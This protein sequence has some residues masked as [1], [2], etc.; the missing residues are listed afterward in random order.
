MTEKNPKAAE[1][2]DFF[3]SKLT[4]KFKGSNI[5]ITWVFVMSGGGKNKIVVY[6]KQCNAGSGVGERPEAYLEPNL[7]IYS[8]AFC[9][10]S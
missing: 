8:G 6:K 1:K 9:E 7:N 2:R 5:A 10:N 4:L 3:K